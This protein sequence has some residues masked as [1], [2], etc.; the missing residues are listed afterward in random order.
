[1]APG[2]KSAGS[3]PA[4]IHPADNGLA[5]T[6]ARSAAPAGNLA[7]RSF[8]GTGSAGGP[9]R[10]P[11]RQPPRRPTLRPAGSS[12]VAANSPAQPSPPPGSRNASPGRWSPCPS[13]AARW[14]TSAWT[15]RHRACRRL[16]G[17]APTDYPRADS[18]GSP[19][20]R[21]PSQ[22]VSSPTGFR[23]STAPVFEG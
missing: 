21:R 18:M 1:M 2:H 3:R 23:T 22:T 6:P 5:D 17:S 9:D 10:S 20:G 11:P 8:A 7:D 14:G 16:A 13:S 12:V 15:G 4:G 19:P